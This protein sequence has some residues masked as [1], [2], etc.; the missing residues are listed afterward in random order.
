VTAVVG[1]PLDLD[2]ILPLSNVP[3]VLTLFYSQ[4]SVDHLGAAE[5]ELEL[6]H[7]SRRFNQWQS[8]AVSGRSPILNWLA[9]GPLFEDGIY[10]VGW[11]PLPPPQAN[12]DA[13]PRNGPAPLPVNF[14]NLSEGNF[15]SSL[16]DF[17]DGI[18]STETFPGHIYKA[19]GVYTVTLTVSGPGG[20]D[21]LVQPGF[22]TVSGTTSKEEAGHSTSR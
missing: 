20:S 21:T 7:Y 18:T 3:V 9:S 6:L 17:G 4:A 8:V 16:W 1:V 13:I 11:R 14:I 15:D 19:A 12:F 2:L 5:A 10:A 22:I